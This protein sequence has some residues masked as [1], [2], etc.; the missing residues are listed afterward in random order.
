M[1]YIESAD[2][3]RG[4][5]FKSGIAAGNIEKLLIGPPDVCKVPAM[6]STSDATAAPQFAAGYLYGVSQHTIDQRE[7]ILDCYAQNDDL[8]AFLYA[9]MADYAAGNRDDGDA[10]MTCS[11]SYFSDAMQKCD[12]TNGSFATAERFYADFDQQDNADAIR[13]TNYQKNKVT[14]DRDAG[15]IVST[16][17]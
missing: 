10:K 11:K 3:S 14:I 2:Y 17:E 5:Y 6:P 9:A 12:Q 13:E 8:T 15:Y 4:N 1:L 16:W 7:Y